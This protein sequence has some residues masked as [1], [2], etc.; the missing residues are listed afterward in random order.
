MDKLHTAASRVT[1]R[2]LSKALCGLG[3]V[4][5]KF[6]NAVRFSEPMR[7]A[8]ILL[9]VLSDRDTVGD[10]YLVSI[11]NILSG[12]GIATREDLAVLLRSPNVRGAKNKR[13]KRTVGDLTL[14]DATIVKPVQP[15]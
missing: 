9:P 3:F 4:R 13:A 10:P 8:V 15:A 14:T 1:F 11:G 6:V 5:K 2:K 7:G 12:K